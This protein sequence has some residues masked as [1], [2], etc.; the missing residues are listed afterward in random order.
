M[1]NSQKKWVLNF[2]LIVLLT[3]FALW[4]A[5]KDDADKVLSIIKDVS[6]LTLLAILAWS[7]LYN[8]L[9][10]CIMTLLARQHRK[11]NSLMSGIIN[12]YVGSFFSGIRQVPAVDRSGR[13]MYLRNKGLVLEIQRVF[14]GWILSF[15]N[16][17]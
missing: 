2:V 13:F 6:P 7:M 3:G 5:L 15:I 4:F 8:V 11:D 10:G 9:V 1:K 14:C 12:G 16:V 17:C